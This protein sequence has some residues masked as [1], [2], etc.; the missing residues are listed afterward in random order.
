MNEIRLTAQVFF[1][2]F[3]SA[4]VAAC[5]G[6]LGAYKTATTLEQHVYVMAEHYDIILEQVANYVERPDASP[7]L[8][9]RL[10]D[11]VRKGQPIFINLEQARATY[12][13]IKT[14]E[15][16]EAL[17]EALDEALRQLADLSKAFGGAK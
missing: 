8:K 10:Q 3:A 4:A 9:A 6:T 16:E 15:S 1:L 17:A 2:L 14:A 12:G 13:A 7:T 11:I 5:T